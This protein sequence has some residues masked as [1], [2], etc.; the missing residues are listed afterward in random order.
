MVI[1]DEC[2]S[3]PMTAPKDWNQKGWAEPTQELV[4]AVVVHDRLGD[5]RAETR[6]ALAEPRRHPAMMQRQ[7]GAARAMAHEILHETK[8]EPSLRHGNGSR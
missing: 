3:M 1:P 2:Q 6:H 7:V 5:H 4:A 8:Q